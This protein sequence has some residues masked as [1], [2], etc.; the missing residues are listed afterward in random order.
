MPPSD[1]F[2]Q[3]KVKAFY[4]FTD[5]QNL[6][7]IRKQGGLLSLAELRRRKI[8]VPKPGGNQWSHDADAMSRVDDYVHLCLRESHPMEYQAKKNGHIGD[9]VFLEIDPD[10]RH[11]AGVMYAPDVSNKSGVTLIAINEALKKIDYEVLYT[12]TDWNDAAIKARLQLAGKCE[13]LVPK[14]VPLTFIR[15]L[16]NG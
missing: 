4:H 2:R 5:K 6:A 16:P 15:N 12:K 7:S 14:H 13:I 11:Q 9:T 3:H 8:V 1:P 10:I